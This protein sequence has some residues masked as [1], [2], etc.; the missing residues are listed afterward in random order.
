MSCGREVDVDTVEWRQGGGGLFGF[1][2]SQCYP[3]YIIGTEDDIAEIIFTLRKP[4]ICR[5][6]VAHLQPRFDLSAQFLLYV[7][8]GLQ[9][10]E[11]R[12]TRTSINGPFEPTSSPRSE[13]HYRN[14]LPLLT[15]EEKVSLLSG[16]TFTNTA[17]V[18]RL[19]IPS[20]K[21]T[22]FERI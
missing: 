11:A 7:S 22:S 12:M 17:G 6:L 15:L 5:H 10:R 14:Q 20:L 1:S 16:M 9:K 3:P 4:L 18:P 19:G 8:S 21:V 13:Y 2:D